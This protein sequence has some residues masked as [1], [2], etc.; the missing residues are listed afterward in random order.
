MADVRLIL[1]V[2]RKMALDVRVFS[3]SDVVVHYI[4]YDVHNNYNF[5]IFL[6]NNI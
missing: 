2:S 5:F 6:N 4:L 3:F 1:R